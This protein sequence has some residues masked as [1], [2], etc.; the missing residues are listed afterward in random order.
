[1]VELVTVVIVS[2][3][4]QYVVE[5]IKNL[6]K[7]HKG[8]YFKNI[9][10]LKVLTSV[11]CSLLMCVAYDIDML[12]LLGLTTDVPFVGQVITAIIVSAGSTTVH[13]IVGK[14]NESKEKDD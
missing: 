13:E 9:V 14:I 3:I 4:C 2:I 5:Q 6:F 8:R 7:Y 11:I 12:S 10:N 1:M